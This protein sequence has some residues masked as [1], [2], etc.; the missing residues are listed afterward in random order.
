MT[1]NRKGLIGTGQ[2]RTLGTGEMQR[3]FLKMRNRLAMVT[4]SVLTLAG[5]FVAPQAAR[6]DVVVELFTSQGCSSCP[7]ADALL[8]KL[9]KK[10]GVIALS[11]HVDYWDYLGWKD[12][13]ALPG[14]TQRQRGYAASAGSSMIYTPQMVIGGKDHLVGTKGMELSEL[15]MRHKATKQPV[16][17]RAERSGNTIVIAAQ[18]KAAAS[19]T[20]VV[21]LVRYSPSET[22]EIKRGE[23]AGRTMTYHNVVT[24]WVK[25][26]DWGGEA[27]LNAQIEA[28]GDL[29]GAVIV[30]AGPTGQVLAAAKVD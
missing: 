14:F 16:E 24:S 12:E 27:P 21:Y 2:R 5:L 8:G 17:L 7:P 9:A 13:F 25:V 1:L 15:I 6:S 10:D 19:G 4:A 26:A 20:M 11:L 3:G 23:N 22:V 30:Q 29:P 28:D 18:P